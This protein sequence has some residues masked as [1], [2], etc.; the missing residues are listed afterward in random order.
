M[1]RQGLALLG[2]VSSTDVTCDLGEA[3]SCFPLSLEQLDGM[4]LCAVQWKVKLLPTV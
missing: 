1:S 3:F 4:M 2:S